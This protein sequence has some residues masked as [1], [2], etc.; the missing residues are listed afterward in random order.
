MH[1]VLDMKLDALEKVTN[2]LV[3]VIIPKGN[4]QD[5]LKLAFSGKLEKEIR[6]ANQNPNEVLSH[7]SQNGCNPKVYK[8]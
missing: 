6:N 7:A 4:K 1:H 2:V 5:P 3:R 8:Q